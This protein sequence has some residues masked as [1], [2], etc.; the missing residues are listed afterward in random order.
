M[1]IRD[2]LVGGRRTDCRL[3]GG[4]IVD[5]GR[6]DPLVGEEVL[7]AA[8]GALVPGL[9]D[10]HLH[11]LASAAAAA[12]VD[13]AGADRTELARR[14]SAAARVAEPSGVR[15]VG[16]SDLLAGELDAVTLDGWSPPGVP[17]RVAHRSGA[18][19]VLNSA[20][21]DRLPTL[22]DPGVERDGAGGPTG[23][24]WRSDHLLRG[25]A[26][27][28]D[29]EAVGRRLTSYGITHLTDATPDLG[30]ASIDLLTKAALPQRLLLLGAPDDW[31]SAERV[32]A[33]PRKIVIAD[34]EPPDPDALADLVAQ[35]HRL[36]RPAAF[37]C[38][39]RTAL[40]VVLAVLEQVGASP[41]DRIEHAAVAGPAETAAMARLG[42]RV[43]TQPSL[44]ARRGDEYLAGSEPPDRADLWPY[45]SLLAAGIPVACSSDGP[46][47]DLDPWAGLRAA[48]DRLTS[49]DQ[50]LGPDQRV[51]VGTAF[52]SLLS[53]PLR[54]GGAPRPVRVGAVADLVLL[55][56]DLPAAL[57]ECT[58]DV[59]RATICAGVVVH[60]G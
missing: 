52:A 45:A 6:S 53:D 46:Y 15:A 7:D 1:L 16:W 31:P 4:V 56:T 2:A 40:V 33:G 36:G 8:G 47:G 19:W 54:P 24:L 37:H 9:A 48:R 34:H 32:V 42:V 59:V 11:L 57:R 44:V 5:L 12:S 51:P 23:R 18:L 3:A 26:R 10:H 60:G 38:V 21:L 28:P 22:D 58:A 27:P 14:L 50:E 49:S 35:C 43:V 29:V 25:A 20:A 17:V 39:S 30:T 41:G 13:L 55:R